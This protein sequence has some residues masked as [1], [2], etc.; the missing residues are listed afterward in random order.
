[1]HSSKSGSFQRSIQ[2][3]IFF[4]ALIPMLV[5]TTA[6]IF[7]TY[8]TLYRSTRTQLNKAAYEAAQLMDDICTLYVGQLESLSD[9]A[10]LAKQLK[11]GR[12]PTERY[13]ALYSFVNSATVRA[14]FYLLNVYGNILGASTT[15][16]PSYLSE[17]GRQTSLI[18]QREKRSPGEAALAGNRGSEEQRLL[19]LIRVGSLNDPSGY[20]L[21]DI[22]WEDF[23]AR[24]SD[25]ANLVLTD[26]HH[27][28]FW[29]TDEL[30]LDSYRRLATDVRISQGQIN[31]DTR[32]LYTVSKSA[33]SGAINVVAYVD[34]TVYTSVYRVII[35]SLAMIFAGLVALLFRAAYRVAHRT[36]QVVDK[37]SQTMEN[38]QHVTLHE[39]LQINTGDEFEK[40]AASY[41]RMCAEICR[42]L[43]D[44]AESARQQVITEIKQLESQFNPHFLFNTLETIRVLVRLDPDS[45]VRAIV[46]LSEI[47]RY[48]IN[49]TIESVLL[50]EEAHYT[51]A[52]LQIQKS[53]FQDML[54]YSIQISPEAKSCIV[55]KLI[56]QPL[57]ENAIQY[58]KD[59]VG[60]CTILINAQVSENKLFIKVRD[61]GEP[62]TDDEFAEIIELIRH[63]RNYTT[64]VGLY[65]VHKRLCLAY[66]EEYGVFFRRRSSGN[67]NLFG[68]VLPVRAQEE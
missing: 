12:I 38:T 66:G 63:P 50:P 28:A 1:M 47:L 7:L 46:A 6:G 40:I 56:L 29:S 39:P 31:R 34:T 13:Q 59:N 3:A 24:L 49:N 30:L 60:R 68:A 25:T 58:G 14:D 51:E 65:N 41:N 67:G 48:S 36:G 44:N 52:Y 32:Q 43:N 21:F 45:A 35:P 26:R 5:I 11:E 8:G 19:L 10:L 62:L 16:T 9:D 4:Y 20:V 22:R 18:W 15:L 2:N 54:T 57:V 53:R 42:L 23:R 64:H 33:F 37:I 27:Y 61:T 55:P 17:E